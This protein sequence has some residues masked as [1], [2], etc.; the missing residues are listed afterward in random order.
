MITLGEQVFK[1][2]SEWERKHLRGVFG[3]KRRLVK[4]A[5]PPKKEKFISRQ[6][7]DN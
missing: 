5:R 6:G 2:L 1:K 7:E 3:V 4:I